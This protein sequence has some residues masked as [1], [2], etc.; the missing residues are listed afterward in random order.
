MKPRK[1]KVDS[2]QQ[3]IVDEL[4]KIPGVTVELGHDDILVGLMDKD[5]NPRTYWYEI[6]R[7]DKTYKNGEVWESEI[8][9]SEQRRVKTWTGHYKIVTSVNEILK[10]IGLK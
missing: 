10:D 6:K 3:D 1:A 8:T 5:F 2:N 7:P 9:E 4:R